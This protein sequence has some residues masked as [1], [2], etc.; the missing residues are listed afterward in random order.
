M[1]IKAK[2]QSYGFRKKFWEAGEI[3]EN[4]TADEFKMKEMKHFEPM[5]GGKIPVPVPD[6]KPVSLKEVGDQN[7]LLLKTNKELKA[8][9]DGKGIQ[10]PPTAN[11]AMLIELLTR[12]GE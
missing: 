6:E 3:A 2:Y 8:L 7:D 12:G 5:G 1:D 9:L 4:V 10:Y 11:K